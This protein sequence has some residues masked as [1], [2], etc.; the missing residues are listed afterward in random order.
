MGNVSFTLETLTR[1]PLRVLCLAFLRL[2]FETGD[3]IEVGAEIRIAIREPTTYKLCS[4][5]DANSISNGSSGP[6]TTRTF[7]HQRCRTRNICIE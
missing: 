3:F 1:Q 2:G 6:I 7:R 4:A 5:G